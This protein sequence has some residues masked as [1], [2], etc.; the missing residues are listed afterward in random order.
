MDEIMKRQLTLGMVS[1]VASWSLFADQ[2]YYCPQNH[3]YINVGMTADQV[4]AACGEP[5]SQQQSNKPFEQKVPVQQLFF[6]NVGTS[7]AF[8]GVWNIQTG[9]GGAQLQVDVVDNKVKAIKLNGSDSNAMSICGGR[10]IQVGDPVGRVY[11]ACGTPSASNNT[12]TMVPIQSGAK[13]IIW[14]YQ[15]GQYQPSVSLTFV[16]GKL[17]SINN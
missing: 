4:V 9:N 3:A 7:T 5:T 13:P 16:N 17:Q 11:G 15:P 10:P 8:Y 6:N 2:S 1:L 14:T 12:Y